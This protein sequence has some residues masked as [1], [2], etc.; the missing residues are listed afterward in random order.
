MAS[1]VGWSASGMSLG[2]E[3]SEGPY[4]SRSQGRGGAKLEHREDEETATVLDER[5]H[6]ED[7]EDDVGLENA[8]QHHV[9]PAVRALDVEDSG[10]AC[11]GVE[12][13]SPAHSS[14]ERV[15]YA[16]ICAC[17]ARWLRV[18][19]PTRARRSGD[20]KN[21]ILVWQG[22][23]HWETW[24]RIDAASLGRRR[25]CLTAN[26]GDG[27][28]RGV[29]EGCEECVKK[30]EDPASDR[31]E[32]AVCV[33]VSPCPS[34]SLAARDSYNALSSS[35]DR[36]RPSTVDLGAVLPPNP[37]AAFF[38]SLNRHLIAYPAFRAVRGHVHR[39]LSCFSAGRD[40]VLLAGYPVSC[41]PPS[42]GLSRNRQ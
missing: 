25:C 3:D 1:H 31:K 23:A 16:R 33:Y 27:R 29:V 12:P 6:A 22:Y 18:T 35:S 19:S 32:I 4:D 39:L 36:R 24:R 42:P 37:R 40:V 5:C 38:L 17:P 41:E 26:E 20:R 11:R 21:Q 8:E 9:L 7:Q 30:I 2:V 28:R 13:R 34:C 15:V 10:P 14:V